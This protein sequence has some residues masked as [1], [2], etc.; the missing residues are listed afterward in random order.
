LIIKFD[1]G[2]SLDILVEIKGRI[3]LPVAAAIGQRS[4]RTLSLALELAL[5]AMP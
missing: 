2:S 3:I 1:M 5:H 4:A